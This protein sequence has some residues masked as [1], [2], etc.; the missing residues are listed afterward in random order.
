MNSVRV[1]SES[2]HITSPPT[3]AC[4]AALMALLQGGHNHRFA[5]RAAK[6]LAW[7]RELGSSGVASPA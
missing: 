4:R 6:V 5:Q 2:N 3:A 7:F 1:A